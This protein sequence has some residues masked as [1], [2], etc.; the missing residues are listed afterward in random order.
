MAGDMTDST[1]TSIS[2]SR[3]IEGKALLSTPLAANRNREVAP[4]ADFSVDLQEQAPA[5]DSPGE[6]ESNRFDKQEGMI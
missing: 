6:L 2:P 4:T 5:C 3:G 1:E